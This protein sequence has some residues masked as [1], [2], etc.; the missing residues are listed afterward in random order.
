MY[1]IRSLTSH[2]HLFYHPLRLPGWDQVL[3]VETR[4]YD[5][6]IPAAQVESQV[7][8]IA[9]SFPKQPDRNVSGKTP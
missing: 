9:S 1:R 6:L 7:V 3:D 2:P 5:S 8:S 4:W